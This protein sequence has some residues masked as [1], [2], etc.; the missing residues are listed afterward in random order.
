MNLVIAAATNMEQK[1]LR[2]FLQS[3]KRHLRNVDLFLLVLEE[4]A[5]MRESE[6]LHWAIIEPKFHISMERN[7]AALELLNTYDGHYD[8]VLLSDSRDVLFQS[9]PFDHISDDIITGLE[10]SNIG[11]SKANFKW[12][13][14]IYGGKTALQL[15]SFQIA[16]S[17]IVLGPVSLV[18]EYLKLMCDEIEGCGDYMRHGPNLDQAMHNYLMYNGPLLITGTQ[19]REGLVATIALEQEENIALNRNQVYVQGKVPPII[20]QYDRWPRLKTQIEN[21]YPN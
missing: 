12:I 19:N 13:S 18:R 20:H 8:K 9:N 4:Q 2:I 16:C 10:E 15:A 5:W 17:G 3:A 6:G 14:D 1:D 21:M 11:N 7:F